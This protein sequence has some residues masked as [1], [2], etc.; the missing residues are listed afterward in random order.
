L[1]E[2]LLKRERSS[3]ELNLLYGET[4][5]ESQQIEPAISHL[6]DAIKYDPRL[7]P[8]KASLGRAYLQIGKAQDAIPYLKEALQ[9][10]PDGSLHY[11]LARADQSTGQAELSKQMMQKSREIQKSADAEQQ[12]LEQE[13]QIT[14]P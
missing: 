7:L 10:D 4:L 3:A 1:L 11:Q 6:R 9:T 13:I 12:K 14:P 8:A 2:E 5:L